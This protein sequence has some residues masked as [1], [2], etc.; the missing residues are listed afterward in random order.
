MNEWMWIPGYLCRMSISVIM[1]D[2]E[3]YSH[4]L[5][6]FRLLDRHNS[7]AGI[8]LDTSDWT[9]GILDGPNIPLMRTSGNLDNSSNHTVSGPPSNAGTSHS[10]W[11]ESESGVHLG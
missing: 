7:V 9:V 5:N 11:V 1:A 4:F 6:K 3:L 8:E 10:T 2:E